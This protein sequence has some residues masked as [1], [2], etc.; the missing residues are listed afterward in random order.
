LT[1]RAHII[2]WY[3]FYKI[4]KSA[5]VARLLPLAQCSGHGENCDQSEMLMLGDAKQR[6]SETTKSPRIEYYKCIQC[7][8]EN[9]QELVMVVQ[10]VIRER[11]TLFVCRGD[12]GK[13]EIG[14]ES[15]SS[16]G[17]SSQDWQNIECRF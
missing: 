6:S 11:Q 8:Q 4:L 13:G 10:V 1:I 3:A 2:S 15:G 17:G 7:I 14:R 9:V 12:E 5:L 16:S